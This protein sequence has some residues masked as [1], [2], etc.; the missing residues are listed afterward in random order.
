MPL[1]YRRDD[2]GRRIRVTATHPITT[3]EAAKVLYRQAAEETWSYGM[4]VD[5][6]RTVLAAADS[7]A[8]LGHAADLADVY[9]RR[10]PVA[11]VTWE[12]VATE[13]ASTYASGIRHLVSAIAVFQNIADA[14]R[15]LAGQ[16]TVTAAA[17]RD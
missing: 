7:D 4:L 17:A 8:L 9:G 2:V 13:R 1:S 6:R 14:E 16:L 15:W 10:G 12:A 11:L 5:L 3:E